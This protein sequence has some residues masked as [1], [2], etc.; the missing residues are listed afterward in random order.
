MATSEIA[1]K[2]KNN[3]T[4]QIQQYTFDYT[5]L[6]YLIFCFTVYTATG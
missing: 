5:E 2:K 6:L 1:T 3:A 4:E